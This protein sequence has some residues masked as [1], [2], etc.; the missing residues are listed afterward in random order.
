MCFYLY[1]RPNDKNSSRLI[2]ENRVYEL[3]YAP[4]RQKFV[5]GHNAGRSY[6]RVYS[7][8]L[9]CC[10]RN[11]KV[12][13]QTSPLLYTSRANKERRDRNTEIIFKEEVCIVIEIITLLFMRITLFLNLFIFN[14]N[15]ATFPMIAQSDF[16]INRHL[17]IKF[18]NI[19]RAELNY[20]GKKKIGKFYYN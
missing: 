5:E 12:Y 2:V 4:S 1:G 10:R 3:S 18:Q 13:V 19:I 17:V 20:I 6:T 7:R 15:L 8:D 11:Y 14:L 9:A 16:P